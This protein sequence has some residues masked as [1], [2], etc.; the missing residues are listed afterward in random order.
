MPG[1]LVRWA[2]AQVDEL[3]EA[4]V[5]GLLLERGGLKPRLVWTSSSKGFGTSKRC[6]SMLAAGSSSVVGEPSD[7]PVVDSAFGFGRRLT[8]PMGFDE[9][10]PLP[11]RI[12]SLW[13]L[14]FR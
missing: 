11:D 6:G 4:W 5:A 3:R 1:A 2:A 13:R 10:A 9:L 14:G 8:F 7:Y 12:P